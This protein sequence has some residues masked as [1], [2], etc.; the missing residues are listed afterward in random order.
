MVEQVCNSFSLVKPT[1]THT[2]IYAT[3]RRGYVWI[4]SYFV[5]DTAR[6]DTVRFIITI[7]RVPF[8]AYGERR[9]T[10]VGLKYIYIYINYAR[11]RTIKE[12]VFA[13]V[14]PYYVL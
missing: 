11:A 5:E 3:E 8:N 13:F 7:P 12:A 9:N 10:A 2:H 6:V 4:L 1:H 14:V